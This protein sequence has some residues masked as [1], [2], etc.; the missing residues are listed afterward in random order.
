MPRKPTYEELEQRV[1]GLEIESAKFKET[2]EALQQ[3]THN[4]GER[5][6]ELNCLFDISNLF[7]K[8]VSLEEIF[9]G[10]V[11]LVRS[12]WQCSEITCARII[13][14]DEEY[15]TINFK[16]T[17]WK[18]SGEIFVTGKQI[19]KLE[20]F[21][22][23]ERP[24]IYEGPF[25]KEEIHLLDEI[26]KRLGIIIDRKRF[27]KAL[28]ES[29]EKFRVIS[30]ASNDMIHLNDKAGNLL[31]ANPVTERLLGYPLEDIL[32]TPSE[33][34]IHPDHQEM[35][36][37]DMESLFIE[38][39]V[40]SPREIRLVKQDGTLMDVEVS[41]FLV[42]LH[43]E[44]KYTGAILRDITDR[45]RAEETLQE[46]EATLKAQSNHLVEANTAL[47][48]LLKQREDDKKD[49][50]ENVLSNVKELVAPHLERLKK[51]G[52]S[53]NQMAFVDV[54]ESNLE[55]IVSPFIGKLSSKYLGLTPMEIRV[56]D[57][58]KQG[59]TNKEIAE[60]LCLSTNTVS[61]H[62]YHL[63]TKLGLKNKKANLRSFLLPLEK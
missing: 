20:V 56:A 31:Y 24:V 60:F 13:L 3:R 36:R 28:W 59:K 63:R 30:T 62:R 5:V 58:V 14:E 12:S 25:L 23:E 52:L 7:E 16:E 38:R 26:T 34:L 54:V 18:H 21:Y 43:E 15:K 49:L 27:E 10:V 9:Q 47:R 11:D 48:V 19:G 4:L 44:H 33:K 6:K 50:Q 8:Q 29:E 17:S 22:L 41:G 40:P 2:E 42:E 32:N 35:I 37:N 45:K 46:S 53:S 39:E 57:L 51:S 1:K 61:G 55:S